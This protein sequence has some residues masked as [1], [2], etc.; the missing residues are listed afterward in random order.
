MNRPDR[1]EIHLWESRDVVEQLK[2]LAD[3]NGS[4]LSAEV[5]RSIRETLRRTDGAQ[6]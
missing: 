1:T 3:E 4:S 2:A 5:R 6:R